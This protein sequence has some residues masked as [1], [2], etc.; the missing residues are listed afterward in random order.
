MLVRILDFGDAERVA[1]KSATSARQ[2][3][4][5]PMR[6][7]FNK[8]EAE[9]RLAIGGEFRSQGRRGATSWRHLKEETIR[10][11]G[12]SR[13]L[14]TKGSNP[15]YSNL[16]NDALFRSLTVRN[17]PDH[18]YNVIGY[19]MEFGTSNPHAKLMQE[20]APGRNIP[21]RPFLRFTKKDME[22]WKALVSEHL[23]KAWLK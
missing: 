10:K 6:S 17:D 21:A 11:K 8:I 3:R 20:G 15:D 14:Y 18:I 16:G 5:V 22:I 12:N 4:P 1:R 9:M 23:M 7:V 2:A 13:I 19:T